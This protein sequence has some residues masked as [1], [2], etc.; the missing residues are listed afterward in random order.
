MAKKS[1]RY[2][3]LDSIR[4]GTIIAMIVYHA[5]WDLV[6]IFDVSIPWF[7]SEGASIWQQSIRWTFLLLSGFCWSLSRNHFKRSLIV[8]GA[9]V[10][11]SGVT[12]LFMPDSV[13]LFG[14]LSLIG[15]AMLVTI[16]LDK[17]FRKLSPYMGLILSAVLF[18]LTRHVRRGTIGVGNFVIA[19]L[20]ES[21]F[22]NYFTAYLGFPHDGF[23]S[24]DYVPVIPWIFLFWAG[25]FLY[26]IFERR[27]WLSGLSCL[28]IEPLEWV[29]RH[30]LV[31]YLLHQPIVYALLYVFFAIK[32]LLG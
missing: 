24:T 16:P 32:Q 23:F 30:S 21:L 10:L 4:G 31:I 7:A 28:H 12:L 1:K 8:L 18:V 2:T 5:L 19:R 6:H 9:S 26:R 15:T 27:K 20:P 13:I 14:V 29:G 17:L 22:A 25:Y 11:I 3:L